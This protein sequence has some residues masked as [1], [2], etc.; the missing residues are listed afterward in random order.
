[1]KSPLLAKTS[2][3]NVSISYK[4]TFFM[5]L[6]LLLFLHF[7]IHPVAEK[8]LSMIPPPDPRRFGAL[9]TFFTMARHIEHLSELF[10]GTSLNNYNFRGPNTVVVTPFERFCFPITPFCDDVCSKRQ[11]PDKSSAEVPFCRN[12]VA[13]TPYECWMTK[14]MKCWGL[15]KNVWDGMQEWAVISEDLIGNAGIPWIHFMLPEGVHFFLFGRGPAENLSH[16]EIMLQIMN[17]NELLRE[18][19]TRK[20]AEDKFLFAGHSRGAGWAACANLIMARSG[21]KK[22]NRFAIGSGAPLADEEFQMAYTQE[23]NGFETSVFLILGIS[24]SPSPTVDVNMDVYPIFRSSD[25]IGYRTMAQF[26]YVC[27]SLNGNLHCL[28]PQNQY[29]RKGGMSRTVQSLRRGDPMVSVTHDFRSYQSCFVACANYFASKQGDYSPNI[30]SFTIVPQT[31]FVRPLPNPL[32]PH[33]AHLAYL[34]RPR[35]PGSSS[36]AGP[37]SDSGSPPPLPP[38]PPHY[39]NRSP[40][41]T[42]IIAQQMMQQNPSLQFGFGP[43]QGPPIPAAQMLSMNPMAPPATQQ[44]TYG[45]GYAQHPSRMQMP[46]TGFPPGVPPNT[47]P[48]AQQRMVYQQVGQHH[49]SSPQNY[50]AQAQQNVP[51]Q[52]Y[53]QPNVLA[54][55]NVPNVAQLQMHSQQS[56]AQTQQQLHPSQ[57]STRSQQQMHSMQ[58]ASRTQQQ[59]N[60]MQSSSRTQQGPRSFS[61]PQRLAS[62]SSLS[63]DA[64]PFYSAPSSPSPAAGV[65]TRPSQ[66]ASSSQTSRA[67]QPS[68]LARQQTRPEEAPTR[69]RSASAQSSPDLSSMRQFGPVGSPGSPRSFGPVGSPSSPQSAEVPMQMPSGRSPFGPHLLSPPPEPPTEPP[70][71]QQVSDVLSALNLD[72]T[73]DETPKR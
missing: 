16:H 34:A 7:Y 17:S 60:P 52:I 10:P 15:D 46:P 25:R 21:V 29:V 49:A 72:E 66:L 1:M 22:E 33:L 69:P 31:T 65:S 23:A 43:R 3:N 48:A 67:R 62:Q 14:D 59:I 18:L 4:A 12:R 30:K 9:T 50:P 64:T 68:P 56:A 2:A 44:Q 53:T 26:A 8:A 45:V 35:S 5:I 6:W 51:G 47:F 57:G 13:S 70:L 42:Q 63:P 19:T 73:E 71:P 11:K 61:P 39:F 24:E 20:T 40:V 27:Y 38:T 54:S 58:S 28:D 55:Q 36:Q 41:P 37:S 32:P